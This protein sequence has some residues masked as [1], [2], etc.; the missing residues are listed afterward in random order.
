[1]FL[2][3]DP[4][5][6]TLGG[7]M[8]G[9]HACPGT[10]P[11]RPTLRARGASLSPSTSRKHHTERHGPTWVHPIP[12]QESVLASLGCMALILADALSAAS[13]NVFVDRWA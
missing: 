9:G 7:R 11:Q 6:R 8:G 5:G 3:I 4:P 10:D 1:M 2:N 13:C 12:I